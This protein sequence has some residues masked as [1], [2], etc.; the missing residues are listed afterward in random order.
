MAIINKPDMTNLWAS[1]GAIIAPSASKVQTGWTAEIPPHQWENWVQ[2][3]QDLALGYLFQRGLAEWDANTEYYANQ[4]VV[5]HEGTIYIANTNN[6]GEEPSDVSSDWRTLFS[7]IPVA[8][9][10]QK[11]VVEI[12]TTAEAQA[13]TNDE[14]ALT[15]KKLADA[16]G[17]GNQL[18]AGNGYRIFPGP[19]GQRLIEQWGRS[20]PHS[21]QVPVT[22]TLPMAFPN[23]ILNLSGTVDLADGL[24]GMVSA[25]V[26]KDG[27]SLSQ[28]QT[29]VDLGSDGDASTPRYV[30]WRAIGR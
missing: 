4:S 28:I 29:A 8:S 23:E 20:G 21:G 12:A 26:G 16:F 5:L 18:L 9:E 24:G 11:G 1:G 10:S 2:N 22:V 6:V 30:Y 17:G 27:S 25:V 15:P 13:M 19:P 3:R 7:D 14:H